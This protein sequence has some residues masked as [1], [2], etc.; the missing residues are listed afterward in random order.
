MYDDVDDA[1]AGAI[2][3]LVKTLLQEGQRFW[4][5]AAY[6]LT[7]HNRRVPVPK[8][9]LCVRLVDHVLPSLLIMSFEKHMNNTLGFSELMAYVLAEEVRSSFLDEFSHLE[10]VDSWTKHI[11][12]QK[13]EDVRILSLFPARYAANSLVTALVR[14][15][16]I[17]SVS[18][19]LQNSSRKKKQECQEAAPNQTVNY[20]TCNASK[21]SS[22]F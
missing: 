13:I 9:R 22:N 6:F 12:S 15:V 19:I 21:S 1:I 11:I 20:A 18:D 7:G 4:G 3:E 2:E 10:P 16:C 5:T 8:W 17:I 14:K